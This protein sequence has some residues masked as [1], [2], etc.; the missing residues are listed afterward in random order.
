[1]NDS[2]ERTSRRQLLRGT[3][4][5]GVGAIL[6]RAGLAGRRSPAPA[7]TPTPGQTE[8]PYYIDAALMRQDIT[9]GRP[10][11]PLGLDLKVVRATTCVPV[12]NAVVD[13]WQTDA[14]GLYSAFATGQ[15]GNVDTSGANFLR[16]IQVTDGNGDASFLTL[17]PGWYPG[18][19]VHIHF[20]VHV[21]NQAVLT[22]QLYFPDAVADEVLATFEPY[23]ER[24]QR[25]TRNSN[26]GIYRPE[27]LMQVT[28]RAGSMRASYQIV[29]P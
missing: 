18:R 8:G 5:L 3:C 1:M 26:D 21:P 13:I 19:T 29:V 27:L 20:K 17:F 10:G 28:P 9:E 4:A 15:I 22:S 7:C 25:T 2:H 11:M 24:G 14:G 23:I 6:A 16:G 12:P